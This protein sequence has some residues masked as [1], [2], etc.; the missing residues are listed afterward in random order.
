MKKITILFLLISNLLNAQF[1]DDFE[2]YNY[3][4]RV[5]PQSLNW[6]TWTEDPIAGTGYIEDEDGIVSNT[7]YPNH[8]EA[9]HFAYSGKQAMF[10]G[11]SRLGS[12]PQDVVLD[13]HNKSKGKWNLTW[14]MYIPR[15][16]RAYYN[17]QEDTPIVGLGNWAIQVYYKRNRRGTIKDDSGSNIV[18][19]NYPQDEWFEIKHTIDLDADNIV[20]ELISN[21][22]T[23]EIYN[24]N[25]LSDTQHLGGVNFYSEEK[26]NKLYIDDVVFEKTLPIEDVYIWDN[27]QWEDVDGN[28]LSGEPDS[29]F[30]VILREPF[31]VGISTASSTLN[32]LNLVF[33]NDGDL[34]IPEQKNVIVSGNLTVPSTNNIL[35][36]DGGSFVMLNNTAIINMPDSNSFKYT[37]TSEVI[38]DK[39]D[40]TYWSSP[41]QEIDVS[42]FGSTAVYTY[43]TANFID[44]FSG[45]GY[46]QTSG[47]PDRHDDNGDDW[48]K[49][50]ST[51]NI[52]SGKGY[53][54]LTSGTTPNHTI[55][56]TGVPNNGLI[57]IPVSLSGDNTNIDDDWNLIGNPYPS[58]IDATVLINSN[59]N[60]SG[61]LYFWTHNTELGGGSNNGP[62]ND[63]YNTNDY[64]SFNL[65]GGIA[66][67]TGGEIPNGF[68]AAGQGFFME[69]YDN[70]VI[71]FNNDMRVINTV[72]EN[73]QF[74]KSSNVKGSNGDNTKLLNKNRIW[75]NF[76]NQN[77]AFSQ[78]LIAFLPGA[79]N[80][81][82]GNY[83][84]VRAG[85]DL[86]T[87][88]YSLL[89][90]K[91]LAIQGRSIY[92]DD[93]QIPLGFYITKP[94]DFTISIDNI[95]GVISTQNMDIYL[96]D[97]QLNKTHNLKEANYHFNV[98]ESGTNN[99][100][101]TLQF[102]SSALGVDDI[103][104]QEN[105][106]IIS[107]DNDFF[108]ISANQIVKSVEVYD[109]LGRMI[110]KSK[111]NKQSFNLSV[112]NV[113]KGSVLVIH[114]QL[115]NGALVSKKA[116]K[117]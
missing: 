113:N 6:I 104:N 19:F 90:D 109:M 29:S 66:A 82:E 21:S 14:K 100:R 111:P 86:H 99:S 93:T 45:I 112:N 42:N 4:Q 10:I 13:L 103:L 61:T 41:I 30:E 89:G 83:D 102:A 77:G 20:I 95:E 94:E 27:D 73:T 106:L 23:T 28:S 46:P 67:S 60:L 78:S 72:D 56:F 16:Q 53:A 92:I 107:N 84:G 44:L 108:K 43:N 24:A 65:S 9:Q 62:A 116:I 98:S 5:S 11:S 57:S 96:I 115:E 25:F 37:R 7:D 59:I 1:T 50:N 76:S 88:F 55:T 39:Y 68:I 38:T 64:A 110:I 117:Y 48:A 75:L 85:T 17:F 47:S 31:T 71:T 58:A 12:Q 63:N 114:A 33:E 69:V 40:F 51:D 52:V 15:N 81:Y 97:H 18:N 2:R 101:F 54:V 91:E 8:G 22:G 35:V 49:A 34:M 3:L 87:K 74:Y 105:N 36:E 79:T 80:D 26:S 32:C 70:G